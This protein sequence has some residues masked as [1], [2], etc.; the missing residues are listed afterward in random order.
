VQN[1]KNQHATTFSSELPNPLI[2]RE[3][4]DGFKELPDILV[5]DPLNKCS[6]LLP[7]SKLQ[8][9][10][11]TPETLTEIKLETVTFVIPDD[12]NYI[13]DVPPFHKAQDGKP[14]ILIQYPAGE[15]AF[16][17]TFADLQ[18]FKITKAEQYAS[19]GISFVIPMG[20]ELIEELPMLMRGVLQ[21]QERGHSRK[22]NG[23]K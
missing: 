13:E 14:S 12:N 15:V 20:M 6:Y 7:A 2:A 11:M 21:T 8:S 18:E 16:Y 10:K 5:Q 3:D 1:I 17:L 9:Y 23:R 4:F 22:I 19:Y